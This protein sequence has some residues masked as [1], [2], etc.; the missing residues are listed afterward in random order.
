MCDVSLFLSSVADEIEEQQKTPRIIAR[1][2]AA[3]KIIRWLNDD[4]SGEAT[5]LSTKYK[6]FCDM[7]P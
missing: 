3:L 4:A 6:R 5:E 2:D 7:N 1:M